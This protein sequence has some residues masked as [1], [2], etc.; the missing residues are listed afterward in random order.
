[1]SASIRSSA[2]HDRTQAL[3]SPPS[4]NYVHAVGTAQPVFREPVIRQFEDGVGVIVGGENYGLASDDNLAVWMLLNASGLLD[5]VSG[6]STSSPVV[7]FYS[8]LTHVNEIAAPSPAPTAAQ[9]AVTRIRALS[10]LTNEEIA[11]LAGVSR[12]S[13]QAWI[14]GEPISARKEQRLRQLQNAIS[15][16]ADA[17]PALTR[18]RLLDRMPGHV[19]PY[20]LLA[21]A[22]FEEAVD[23]GL[24]RHRYVASPPSSGQT[25][26]EQLDHHEH[27]VNLPPGRLDR[28]F[29]GRLQR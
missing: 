27:R 19:R 21:E 6:G 10:N 13:L 11:P 26:A 23:L 7:A 3:S 9:E 24:G 25:L 14:A 29:A 18:R 8:P 4:K 22:R 12:R 20:D 5:A 28:R 1:M 15:E 16:V 17:S 2:V